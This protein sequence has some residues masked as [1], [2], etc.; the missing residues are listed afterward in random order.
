[1]RLNS[2][3]KSNQQSR[4]LCRSQMPP[5]TLSLI[6][7]HQNYVDISLL[8]LMPSLLTTRSAQRK[9]S[10]SQILKLLLFVFVIRGLSRG[11]FLSRNPR[12]VGQDN[13]LLSALVT[14]R[15]PGIQ[16]RPRSKSDSALIYTPKQMAV[17]SV[18]I[19]LDES[20]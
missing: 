17:N 19:S 4:S 3:L 15:K 18:Y 16:E 6:L 5:S 13:G 20:D 11:F 8:Q 7:K 10:Y 1:M 9:T 12:I 2:S 14:I